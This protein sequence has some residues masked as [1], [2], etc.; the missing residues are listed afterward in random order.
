VSGYKIYQLCFLKPVTPTV[1]Q[2][3]KI[4]TKGS[5]HLDL[6][7]DIATLL[8]HNSIVSALLVAEIDLISYYI[9][10]TELDISESDRQTLSKCLTH[11]QLCRNL[12]KNMNVET[13]QQLNQ[14]A[15]NR[16]CITINKSP[17]CFVDPINT[18]HMIQTKKE[19]LRNERLTIQYLSQDDARVDWHNFLIY[20]KQLRVSRLLDQPVSI[21]PPVI[22]SH[23]MARELIGIFKQDQYFQD[24]DIYLQHN[25]FRTSPAIRGWIFTVIYF[26]YVCQAYANGYINMAL[27]DFLMDI[28]HE[29]KMVKLFPEIIPLKNNLILLHR[30]KLISGGIND[31]S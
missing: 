31:E 21:K 15:F 10:L 8:I 13:F 23:Q 6:P 18:I 20:Y 12:L 30:Y 24:L 19:G 29:T 16:T 1:E 3:T 27:Y 22:S 17:V 5:I 2:Q 25:G 28:E 4:S 9:Q 14:T 7:E 26:D 11:L